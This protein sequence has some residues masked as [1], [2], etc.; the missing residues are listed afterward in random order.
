[1]DPGAV[2]RAA[3]GEVS[4]GSLV[5]DA[6]GDQTFVV[7]GVPGFVQHGR[8]GAGVELLTITC[9]AATGRALTPALDRWVHERNATMLLG[10]IVLIPAEN[11]DADVLLRYCL[12]RDD[13]PTR[14]R[15]VLLPVIAAAADVR[16]ELTGS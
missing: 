2:V 14:L 10:G 11:G 7:D 1:M 6:E 12:P 3:L 8:L 13:D 15:S 5:S 16:R 4:D 9:L